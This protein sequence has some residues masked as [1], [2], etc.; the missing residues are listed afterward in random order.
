[1]KV[2]VTGGTGFVGTEIIRQLTAAGHTARCLVRT[3]SEHKMEILKGVEIRHGDASQPETLVDALK[4]C[5]AVIHLIGIIREF[6]H[7]GITFKKLHVEATGNLLQAAR[8]QGVGRFVHMSSN[9]TR[10]GATS[11]Y[12]QSKWAAEELVR[13]S[14]LDWTIFRPSVI[15]GPGDQFINM[16]ADMMHKLPVMPVIGDG[17]YRM[18]PV[19]VEDVAKGFIKSLKL[20][21]A[22]GQVYHCCGPQALTYDEILDE[23]GR[24]LGKTSVTKLHHPLCLMKP[25]VGL[26]DGFSWFP[27]TRNQLTMMLEGNVCD[28]EPWAKTFGIKPTPLAEGIGRYLSS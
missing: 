5:E 8:E 9:G 26:L 10:E 23:I 12:H 6:P 25:V 4:G 21:E 27:L 14:D 16:L 15:F 19:A 22:S 2:F 18:S 17:A 24:A 7:K 3:G 13:D 20:Q 11:D 28:P 1:M